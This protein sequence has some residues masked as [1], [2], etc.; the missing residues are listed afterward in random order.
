MRASCGLRDETSI[1]VSYSHKPPLWE[2][3]ASKRSRPFWG[4]RTSARSVLAVPY[5]IFHGALHI[6]L[7]G[8]LIAFLLLNTTPTDFGG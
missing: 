3:D 8:I 4:E 7:F 6:E 5:V 1:E 2:I